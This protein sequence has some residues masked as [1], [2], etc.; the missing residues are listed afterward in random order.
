MSSA[1]LC[2]SRNQ[3]SGKNV[4]KDNEI[5]SNDGENVEIWYNIA[6]NHA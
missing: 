4:T 1:E 2:R 6:I 5:E 3:I